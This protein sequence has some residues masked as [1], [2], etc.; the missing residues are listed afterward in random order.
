MYEITDNYTMTILNIVKRFKAMSHWFENSMVVFRDMNM[1]LY[2]NND[3]LQYKKMTQKVNMDLIVY[4]SKYTIKKTYMN[5]R[6]L[7][8]PDFIW[9]EDVFYSNTIDIMYIENENPAMH[10][11][12]S[13]RMCMLH[14]IRSY[15]FLKH[16]CKSCEISFHNLNV[17]YKA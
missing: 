16:Y 7:V 13:C 3:F 2:I 15:R 12:K 14:Y 9:K 11:P 8:F 17:K 4:L 1:I 6:F 10:G 5:S